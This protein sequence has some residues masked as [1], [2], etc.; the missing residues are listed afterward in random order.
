[1]GCY[2]SLNVIFGL[3]GHLGV[4]PLPRG[5][6]RVP[7]LRA[8]TTSAFHAGHHVHTH[9]NY[10]FYTRVWDRLAGTMLPDDAARFDGL[11]E[12]NPSLKP[13][14]GAH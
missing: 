12:L 3:L 2:L 5:L 6:A 13:A 10:G 7:G 4:E 11:P 1:M 8:L 14:E 9:G